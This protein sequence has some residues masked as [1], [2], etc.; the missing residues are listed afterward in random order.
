MAL[1]KII[2]AIIII[3]VLHFPPRGIS[4]C[5]GN[6]APGVT[7]GGAGI[8]VVFSGNDRRLRAAD[9]SRLSYLPVSEQVGKNN[10][11]RRKTRKLFPENRGSCI[12][13]R[14]LHSGEGG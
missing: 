7:R 1:T 10:R 3:L 11:S 6:T 5:G 4:P 8:G 12:I 14:P 9:D 2:L 13:P